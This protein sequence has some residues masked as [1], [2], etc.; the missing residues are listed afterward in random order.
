M[1]KFKK[2]IFELAIPSI[3]ENILQIMLSTV[4]TYFVA[5]IGSLAISAVGINTL[6]SNLYLTFFIALG[7]GIGI[8]TARAD[9]E[10]NSIKVKENIQNGLLM[11]LLISILFLI[12]NIV[13]GH[14]FL[15]FIGKDYELVETAHIYFN[16][17]II[18]IASLS[19]MT[20]LSS[21]LKSLG[22][23]KTPMMTVFF[24]NVINV[25]LD[26]ILIQRY[27][28]LGAGM[29]TTFSR[30]VAC[31]IL[32]VQLNKRTGFLSSFK[33]SF[34]K[35][36]HEMVKYAI[37][38]GLEKISM[39]IGQLVYGGLIVTIGITHYTAHNIAGTIEGYSYL[40]AMGFGVAAFTIIGHAIGEKNFH[41]IKKIGLL[42]FKYSTIFMVAI[43]IVFFVFAPNLAGIFTDD[44]EIIRLVTMVLRIIA[45]FQPFLC[46][47]QVIASSL[48]ALGDVK[49]PFYLTTIGIWVI[50]ILGTLFFGIYL[51][52]GLIGVWISY[53]IDVTFRGSLLWIRFKKKTK[54]TDIL[55]KEFSYES[56]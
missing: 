43:G 33:L 28:I 38:V 47:T 12:L 32:M 18:P 44:P 37:P 2:N 35:D 42:T 5:T 11:T 23:T 4:D 27:G 52:M 34:T 8:M 46:S 14:D 53:A 1:T 40:P 55:R 31:V 22:D 13:F 49:Y 36:I 45:L 16:V 10:N 48:Q 3:I 19:F 7:T 25:I 20:V 51:K 9:G 54:D 26:Y 50:R 17:V 29:A 39:R 41:D 56:S 24:I 30:L 6:I 15:H 21:I